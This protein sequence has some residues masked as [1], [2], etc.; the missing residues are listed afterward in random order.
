MNFKRLS[1]FLERFVSYMILVV[2][3]TSLIL[4]LDMSC[5]QLIV[6]FIIIYTIFNLSKI[7]IKCNAYPMKCY[8]RKMMLLRNKNQR[9]FDKV[10]DDDYKIVRGRFPRTKSFKL[11]SITVSISRYLPCKFLIDVRK[12]F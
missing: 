4:F 3:V 7:I 8:R 2:M 1:F 12:P 10:H 6:I 5:K 9:L 11:Y